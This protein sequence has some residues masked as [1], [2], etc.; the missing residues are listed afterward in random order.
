[1]TT[2]ITNAAALS[3]LIVLRGVNK[4]SEI[5][6]KHV[7][8]GY[9]VETAADDATYWSMATTMR[10]DS[11]NLS[12]IS[13]ALGM[14]SSKVD[15][16]YTAMSNAVDLVTEIRTKLVASREPGVS[17]DQV[18]AE[19]TALK[20]Q[21]KSVTHS[22]TFAGEN[23]LL[24]TNTNMPA[25]NSVVG[26]FTRGPSGEVYV[27]T[28]D[29]P[30]ADS[31]L[32]DTANAGR[33]ILTRDYDANAYWPDG[34]TTPRNYYLVDDGST[35]PAGGKEI[36]LDENTTSADIDDMISVTD[37]IL[38]TVTTSASKLGTMKSRI[39]SQAT[40]VTDLG[41]IIDKGVGR[42]VDADMDEES[43]R[44]KAVETQKQM[45]VQAIAIAN[46]ASN[47]LLLLLE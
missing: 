42:L 17:M 43:A 38:K 21:L 4:E 6:Q 13:D 7:A 22:S 5:T 40:F 33:G 41:D 36:A 15:I 24:N 10:S 34:T 39:E 29:F 46:D 1:M 9:R 18:N 25:K 28:A 27:Q 16:A 47:K 14:G 20:E 23:W 3:A 8:S 45:G 35:I 30:A 31:L 12:T 19:I 26:S 11:S 32:I 37:A 2:S 44:Q